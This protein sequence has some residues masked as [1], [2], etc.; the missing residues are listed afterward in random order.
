MTNINEVR[1]SC[2]KGNQKTLPS[3]AVYFLSLFQSKCT[4]VLQINNGPS[5]T[6][7]YLNARTANKPVTQFTWIL[8]SFL[9][10]S[11]DQIIP[12]KSRKWNL[13]TVFTYSHLNKPINLSY[14]KK[15]MKIFSRSDNGRAN[16]VV[17]NVFWP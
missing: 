1:I 7:P 8:T 10:L 2:R 11:P 17:H 5:L 12:E 4:M 16:S 15:L 13:P 3:M 9:P 14:G 6:Q